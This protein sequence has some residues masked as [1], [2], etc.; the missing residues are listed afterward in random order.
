MA[1]V[2]TPGGEL[3]TK[4]KTLFTKMDKDGDGTITKD[5]KTVA[6]VD[7]AA[8]AKCF[9]PSK[10]GPAYGLCFWLNRPIPKD[11]DVPVYQHATLAHPLVPKDVVMAAGAGDQRCYLIPSLELVVVRQARGV[12][13]AVFGRRSGFT[14]AELLCRLLRGCD[15]AG[16]NLI[17]SKNGSNSD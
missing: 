9:Q 1:T 15:G 11:A 4:V 13:M 5:D 7:R 6:L 16:T 8:L 10:A 2:M 17:P 14:D 3:E 12:L